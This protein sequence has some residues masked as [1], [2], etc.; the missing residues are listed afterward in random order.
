MLKQIHSPNRLLLAIMGSL[1]GISVANAVCLPPQPRPGPAQV[2]VSPDGVTTSVITPE[3]TIFAKQDPFAKPP[4]T[5]LL[6]T[7]YI[8]TCDGNGVEMPNT[9]PSSPSNPYNLHP[10][11]TITLIDKTS[12]WDD[13]STV[14]KLLHSQDRRSKHEEDSSNDKDDDGLQVKYDAAAVQTAIDIL[15]GNPLSGDTLKGKSLASRVYSGIPL[16]HY[17][18][19]N[20]V[21]VVKPTFDGN[22]VLIGGVVNVHQIWFEDRIESDTAFIDPSAVKTVP[23]TIHYTIDTLNRG[24]DD[25]APMVMYTDDPALSPTGMPPMPHVMMDQTFFPMDDGTRTTFDVAMTTGK[26]YNLSYHWGWRKHPPKA[27]V[28]ENALKYLAGKTLPQWEQSVFGVDPR[29]NEAAKLAAIGKISDLAP[30]KRLWNLL[31][32][33]QS[34]QNVTKSDMKALERA[35]EQSKNRLAL[36]DGVTEDPN[37]DYTIF[38]ANNTMYGHVKGFT[39]PTIVTL[40]DFT[41][42]GK[43]VNVTLLNGDYFDHAYFH[44]DFGG[45]RGWENTFQSTEAIGGSGQWFTFGR[46]HW[47]VNAGMPPGSPKDATLYSKLIISPA[48]TGSGDSTVIGVHKLSIQLNFD[49]SRRLRVYQFDPLHHETAIWSV[50]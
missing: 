16:L 20:K 8:N 4:G 39:E 19:P 1:C 13:L 33:I 3:N 31:Y 25:F 6:P 17:N 14:L 24:Q 50:H 9:L 29:A 48:A 26:Y 42:R 35:F 2:S 45:R 21:Q 30:E 12:P 7:Q 27:Q 10:T 40:D 34:A 37:S 43:T 15:E 46:A 22:G 49:P 11:P 23:W 36:P 28:H 5:N 18:G 44:I 41:V 32:K 38:Y 47:W